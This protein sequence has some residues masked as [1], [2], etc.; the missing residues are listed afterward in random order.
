MDQIDE[1]SSQLDP[2]LQEICGKLR[3]EIDSRLANRQSKLYHGAP[4]WFIDDIPIVGYSKKKGAIALLFWSGQSFGEGGLTPVG[5][6]KAAEISFSDW[7][8]IDKDRLARWLSES[9]ETI[10]DYKNLIKNKGKLE[11]R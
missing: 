7:R 3:Q 1:Y 4:V 10:W 5:K 2:D 11:M 8:E 6:H 9:Q